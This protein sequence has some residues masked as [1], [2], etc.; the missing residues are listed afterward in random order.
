MQLGAASVQA[1]LLSSAL[2]VAL[3]VIAILSG[4]L[5]WKRNKTS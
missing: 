3:L 5:L 1:T 2:K 4:M